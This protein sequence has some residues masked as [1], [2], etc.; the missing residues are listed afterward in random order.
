MRLKVFYLSKSI[1]SFTH[2]TKSKN[3][4]RMSQM[5]KIKRDKNVWTIKRRL[6]NEQKYEVFGDVFYNNE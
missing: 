1:K 5:E 6:K 2:A 3:T 4:F